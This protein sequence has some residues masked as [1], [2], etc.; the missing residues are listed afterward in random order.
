VV[1]E[2]VHPH[3]PRPDGLRSTLWLKALGPDYI[4]LAY[5][6]AHE[7]DQGLTLV[8]NDYGTEHGDADGRRKR[9]CVL[10]LLEKCIKEGVPIHAF[11]LQSHLDA[12][13][14]LAGNE[15]TSFLKEV[16]A[17]GLKIYITELDLNAMRL[18][19]PINDR[20]KLAQNYVS[21]YLDMVQKDGIVDML[22]TWGLS[23]RYTWLRGTYKDVAGALPLDREMRRNLLW[24]SLK[25][26]WLGMQ[27]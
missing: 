6:I 2:A 1:N 8:Y 24:Y 5:R 27:G 3:S 20:I 16:R 12:H 18:S 23:D 10:R 15:F 7:A 11:G 22:L 21:T 26:S 17:L 14:P 4:S 13:R 25:K 9:Q 19:G